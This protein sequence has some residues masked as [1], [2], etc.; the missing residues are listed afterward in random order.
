[1]VRNEFNEE[2]K[3]PSKN[4]NTIFW[5]L[6]WRI[7]KFP[8]RLIGW[9]QWSKRPLP[10]LM[11]YNV[12]IRAFL[13]IWRLSNV[14]NNIW[15]PAVAP[16]IYRLNA[17]L[18]KAPIKISLSHAGVILIWGKTNATLLWRWRTVIVE[19]LLHFLF[20]CDFGDRDHKLI[21]KWSLAQP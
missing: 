11:A 2:K 15:V 13:F 18:P 4:L 19:R 6:I 14:L 5:S 21:R 12:T 20:R 1:M 10:S 17:F 9:I 8:K 7:I 3:N 16:P